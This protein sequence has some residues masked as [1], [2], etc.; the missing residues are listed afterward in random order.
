MQSGGTLCWSCWRWWCGDVAVRNARHSRWDSGRRRRGDGG[1]GGGNSNNGSNSNSNVSTSSSRA[2][3]Q[4]RSSSAQDRQ[5][6]A[7]CR[8]EGRRVEREEWAED[9]GSLGEF[10]RGR[11]ESTKVGPESCGAL[12]KERRD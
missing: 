3:K 12:V 7:G 2:A 9:E 5:V 4:S 1:G 10:E 11:G 6:T 8:C